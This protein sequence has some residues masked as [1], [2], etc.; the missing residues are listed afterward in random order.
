MSDARAY[1]TATKVPQTAANNGGKVLLAG[2][3]K[4]AGPA[5]AVTSADFYDPAT[6]SF[7][8]T[9]AITTATVTSARARHVAVLLGSTGVILIAGGTSDDGTTIL[10]TALEYGAGAASPT[11]TDVSNTMA[12]ARM[13]FTGT[14]L[15]GGNV[16]VVGGR[17]GSTTAD[18]T[19]ELFDPTAGGG[20][21]AF[22]TTGALPAGEDKRAHTAVLISGASTNAG[23]V[24][25][26]GGATGTGTPSV[27]QFLYSSGAFTQ[28]SS[29]ATPRSNHAAISLPTDS[30]LIC[31]GTSTG[32]NTL[33]S[34]ER[35]DPASGLGT[36]FPTAAM[37]EARKDFGLAPITISSSVEILAAGSPSTPMNY[38]ET[39]DTN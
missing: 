1:H 19:A 3:F 7:A 12:L 37:L 38:A 22:S 18:R 27:T 17:M 11:R 36:M 24:L 32:T 39:Y 33:S 21:G 26:S 13:D 25:I 31:G 4:D 20:T 28:I 34:C 9:N 16:L 23:K 2:G 15:I 6:N 30:V 8:A 14:V 35:Y 29:L 10:N 5:T